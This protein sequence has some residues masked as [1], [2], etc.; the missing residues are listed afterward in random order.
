M[1]TTYRASHGRPLRRDGGVTLLELLVVVSIIGIVAALLTPAVQ[2][3]REVARSVQCKSNLKQLGLALH[4]YAIDYNELPP[5]GGCAYDW[6]NGFVPTLEF[7]AQ[8]YLLPYL[9]ETAVFN[10]INFSEQ[11]SYGNGTVRSPMNR[12][13]ANAAL[14]LYLCPSDPFT[15]GVPGNNYRTCLGLGPGTLGPDS[16]RAAFR[17]CL[18]SRLNDITDGLVMTALM[19]EK[20]KGDGTASRFSAEAEFFFSP[21]TD[22]STVNDTKLACD[23]APSSNPR[24]DSAVGQAWLPGTFRLT[25]YNHLLTPNSRIPDCAVDL[26]ANTGAFSA[27]SYHVGG[28]HVLFADGRVGFVR[29]SVFEPVW[30]SIASSTSGDNEG[31]ASF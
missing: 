19:S 2:R 14:E 23:N 16:P 1:L 10:S 12:T 6:G 11:F 22:V 17:P 27:R 9:S 5:V 18:R 13:A 28:V 7:S 15:P 24:H 21:F 31:T 25:W 30:H 4:S 20:L 29:D 3:S 26:S 8:T